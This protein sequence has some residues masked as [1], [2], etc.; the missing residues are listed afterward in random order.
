MRIRKTTQNTRNFNI[1]DAVTDGGTDL[2]GITFNGLQDNMENAIDGIIE[3]GTV[4]GIGYYTKFSDGTIL[5]Y[6]ITNS[7]EFSNTGVVDGTID[8]SSFELKSIQNAQLTLMVNYSDYEN[9]KFDIHMKD[10]NTS[11]ITYSIRNEYPSNIGFYINW[12]AIGKWK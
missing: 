10:R 6:G 9:G 4:T 12:L 11:A 3:S 2:N 5:C 7:V 8:I 1:T